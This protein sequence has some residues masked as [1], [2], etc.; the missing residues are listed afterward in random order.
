[1]D[2]ILLEEAVGVAVWQPVIA[3]DVAF[4]F[5][6]PDAQVRINRSSWVPTWAAEFMNKYEYPMT[7]FMQGL[8]CDE[9]G[10]ERSVAANKAALA[11]DAVLRLQIIKRMD[12][13]VG[14][15]PE[16]LQ[17]ILDRLSGREYQAAFLHNKFRTKDPA[18]SSLTLKH[19]LGSQLEHAVVYA[20]KQKKVSPLDEPHLTV[21][22]S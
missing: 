1:M 19:Y 17:E 8:W 11:G 2:A 22:S 3:D 10:T 15:T 6:Q 18:I 21:I 9:K 12:Q 13:L 20:G 5:G 4:S 14:F 16:Q 7:A